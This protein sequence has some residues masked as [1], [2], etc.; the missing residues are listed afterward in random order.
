MSEENIVEQ[1]REENMLILAA[2]ARKEITSGKAKYITFE[3]GEAAELYKIR[4]WVIEHSPK[5]RSEG[6]KMI[7]KEM[8]RLGL[9]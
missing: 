8:E 6:S 4:R 3:K 2:M 9:N 7:V 1:T 5:W